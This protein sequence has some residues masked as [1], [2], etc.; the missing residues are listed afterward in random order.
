L[1]MRKQP[2]SRMCFIC[3]RQNPAGLKMDFYEDAE[4]GQVRSELT[5]P[6]AYQGYPGVVHGGIVAAILDEVSGRAIMMGGND[7][8]LMAT[9]RLTIRYR[10]P[11]PTGTP[12]TAVGW[13]EQVGGVG[14]RVAGE[15]RLPDGTVTAECEAVLGNVSEEFRTRWEPEKSYWRVYE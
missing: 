14:A 13:V 15:I 9:L 10:R 2:N 1:K 11:T 4:A 3:G 8:D 6:D 7:D 12:L 5:V